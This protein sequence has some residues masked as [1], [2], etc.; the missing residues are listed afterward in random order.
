MVRLATLD[1][2][3]DILKLGVE[4]HKSIPHCSQSL[5][6]LKCRDKIETFLPQRKDWLFLVSEKE[7]KIV[8][9][10]IGMIYESFFSSEKRSHE[11]VWYMTPA[12]AKTKDTIRLH[13][14]FVYWSVKAGCTHVGSSHLHGDA[15]M[16]NYYK[17]KGFQPLEVSYM[18][19]V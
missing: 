7:G 13:D 4:F 16:A 19:A 14:V 15:A 5:D 1:D 3:G 17:R 12:H 11:L 6:L 8:G 10:L 18:K 9:M 2:I